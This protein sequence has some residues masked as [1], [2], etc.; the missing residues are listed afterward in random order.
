MQFRE[1]KA[2]TQAVDH[3]KT[4]EK[5]ER[6]KYSFFNASPNSKIYQLAN[7]FTVYLLTVSL[8]YCSLEKPTTYSNCRDTY[9]LNTYDQYEI[10][11]PV[12]SNSVFSSCFFFNTAHIPQNGLQACQVCSLKTKLIELSKCKRKNFSFCF[13]LNFFRNLI[14][15]VDRMNLN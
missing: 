5:E 8:T 10:S 14:L 12:T 4:E 9:T 2:D 6:L 13:Q 3:L 11:N 7:N 1:L 15:E